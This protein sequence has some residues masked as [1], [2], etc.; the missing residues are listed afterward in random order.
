MLLIYKEA[1][2]QCVGTY[3][4]VGYI[5]M[6]VCTHTYV[7][8]YTYTHTSLTHTHTHTSDGSKL[9]QKTDSNFGLEAFYPADFSSSP[10]SLQS[11]AG[12]LS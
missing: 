4:H 9:L 3:I 7:H 2:I 11:N 6:Y 12:I 5:Y 1:H 8:T 10:H